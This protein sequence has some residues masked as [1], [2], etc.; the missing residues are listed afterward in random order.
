MEN[1]DKNNTYVSTRV[2]GTLYKLSDEKN[3]VKTDSIQI[4]S[5]VNYYLAQSIDLRYRDYA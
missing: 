3:K 1:F 5:S 2:I 4:D